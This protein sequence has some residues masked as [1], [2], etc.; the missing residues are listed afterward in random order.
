MPPACCSESKSTGRSRAY[1]GRQPPEG[2]PICTALNFLA[3]RYAAAD[4]EN[5]LPQR[6]AHGHL[7]QAGVAT[8]PASAKTAVPALS[9][10]SCRTTRH[11][12]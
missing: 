5:N 3:V 1:S 7:G 6:R 4:V 9:A 8:L 12:Y 10:C 2:P 11:R